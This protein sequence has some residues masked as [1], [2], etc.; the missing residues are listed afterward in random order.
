M[1]KK[2]IALV[3]IAAMAATGAFAQLALGLS[4]SLYSDES[5]TRQE[6]VDQFQDG[7][8]IFYGP[9]V[10][11]GLGKLG[12]GL[13]ANFSLYEYDYFGAGFDVPMIEYDVNLYLQAHFF[14]YA[15]FLDPFVEL[16]FGSMGIDFQDTDEFPDPDPEN[17]LQASNYWHAGFGLGLNLGPLG[18]FF[19]VLY[20]FDLG[21]ADFTYYDW[22]EVTPGN[23]DWEESAAPGVPYPLR[24][25]KVTIGAKINL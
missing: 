25:L 10:E 7:T 16:G 19:K 15:A 5:L 9:F 12:L 6:V 23:F 1:S 22:V 20:M 21:A 18:A 4:G 11:L 17:P 13:A 2:I 3:A 8:G 24:K 14:G